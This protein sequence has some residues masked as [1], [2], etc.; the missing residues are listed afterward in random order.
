MTEHLFSSSLN[1][2]I[3][4]SEVEGVETNYQKFFF[5]VD[6]ETNKKFSDCFSL[7]PWNPSVAAAVVVAAVVAA[8]LPRLPSLQTEKEKYSKI[9]NLF[10]SKSFS[11]FSL[12]STLK[13]YFK[14]HGQLL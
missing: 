4:Q 12:A 8:A 6:V 1:F 10:S 3:C 7:L 14:S 11:K 2:L 5:S 13:G 9:G